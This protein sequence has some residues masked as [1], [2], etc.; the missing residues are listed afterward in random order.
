MPDTVKSDFY[1]DLI[2]EATYKLTSKRHQSPHKCCKYE[3]LSK[4]ITVAWKVARDR[5]VHIDY[6]ALWICDML[7]RPLS[8]RQMTVCSDCHTVYR[9]RV[10]VPGFLVTCLHMQ[11]EVTVW[12]VFPLLNLVSLCKPYDVLYLS[13]RTWDMHTL[14]AVLKFLHSMCPTHNVIQIMPKR[15]KILTEICVNPQ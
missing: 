13:C 6:V 11:R 8:F 12:S 4:L 3:I 5:T 2:L 9:R 15:I 7:N 10:T 1:I 14:P